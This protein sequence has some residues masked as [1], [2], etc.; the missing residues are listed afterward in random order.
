MIRQI[1]LVPGFFGFTA[2]GAI[3]YFRGVSEAL[4]EALAERRLDCEIV[5]C[6]T[7]PTGS[8][9]RRAESILATVCENG[10][11]EAD[12]LYFVGHSTGGLDV[13]LLTTPG[14][15]LAP[16]PEEDAIVRKTRSVIT[17]ATP[18][19]G[20]PLATLFTTL[21]GRHLL[22]MLALLATTQ[23]GRFALYGGSRLIKWV[24]RADDLFG[25]RDTFLDAWVARLLGDIT[26]TE[27]DPVWEYF[28]HVARDQGAI[29]QLTPESLD[30]FNAAVVDAR[31]IAYGCVVTAAPPPPLHYEPADLLGLTR[32]VFAGAF[33][34]MHTLAGREHRH[35][36]YPHPG[37]GVIAALGGDLGFE[38]HRGTNDGVVPS[39]SQ[40]YGKVLHVA[41]ADHLDVV[42]Q[43]DTGEPHSDWLPSGSHF[44]GRHF[45]AIWDAVAGALAAASRPRRTEGNGA[46]R[47][48]T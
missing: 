42:G 14:V 12:E 4:G 47:V 39:L 22:E 2:L 13:R 1:Y 16:G 37:D 25:R 15:R 9:R 38:V 48:H 41:R 44:D 10:G 35:Y 21:P 33:T 20:T 36:P 24:A 6:A 30:L 19:Y 26:R 27:D 11:L 23:G 45:R 34:F 32:L 5:E 17:V 3:N 43:Y 8:I 7:Q 29:I 28:R 46:A 18:H 40:I 31:H